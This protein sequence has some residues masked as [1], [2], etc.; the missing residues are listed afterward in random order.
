MIKTLQKIQDDKIK[1]LVKDK[2]KCFHEWRLKASFEDL[3]N[4]FKDLFYCI[5]C[6]EYIKKVRPCPKDIKEIK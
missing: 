4:I 1:E 3:D 5:R 2:S 6:L